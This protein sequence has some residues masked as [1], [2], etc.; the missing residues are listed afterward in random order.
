MIDP[1]IPP[2]A[3]PPTV[4]PKV[5]IKVRFPSRSA[6]SGYRVGTIVQISKTRVLVSFKYKGVL[7][8]ERRTGDITEPNTKWVRIVDLLPRW[9]Y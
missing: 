5:G 8:Y 6:T 4:T 7:E 2:N 1:L 9:A 3:K